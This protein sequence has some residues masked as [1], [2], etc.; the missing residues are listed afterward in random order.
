MSEQAA[1]DFISNLAGGSDDAD[2]DEADS[3]AGEA[4]LAGQAGG[5]PA[6]APASAPGAAPSAGA[7]GPAD[8]ANRD[9][10]SNLNAALRE[11]RAARKQ[12]E[13]R[14]A[15]IEARS[16]QPAPA[17]AQEEEGPDFLAD[18]K[19][20][21]DANAKK[22]K[23]LED[24]L[25]KG[26]KEEEDKQKAQQQVQE[27]WNKVISSEQEFAA[28]TPDYHDALNHVRGVLRTQIELANPDLEDQIRTEHPE[29]T[30]EQVKQELSSRIHR[31]IQ[32]QEFQGAA[33]LLA[34]GKN[35]SKVYYEY[36]KVLGYKPK[37]AVPAANGVGQPAAAK[38][39]KDAVRSMGSGGGE[40]VTREPEG[41]SSLLPELSMAHAE[42]KEDR[43]RSARNR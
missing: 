10:V 39:D 35:P 7:G 9:H 26:K 12:L 13:Q 22:L 43:K 33:H 37:A 21:V 28:T 18:P 20:Y 30:D 31:Q 24:K 34:K 2:D 16:Q 40:G 27:T 17:A 41:R 15:A 11:E 29:A 1:E 25:E 23:E 5:S 3:G 42:L 19:G 38:P 32:I 14:L 6:A 4:A 8:N 36:A